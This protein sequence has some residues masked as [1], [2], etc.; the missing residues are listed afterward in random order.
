MIDGR[1]RL[2]PAIECRLKRL[3]ISI[4]GESL[5]KLDSFNVTEFNHVEVIPVQ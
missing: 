3:L 5:E 2:I 1:V 4:S